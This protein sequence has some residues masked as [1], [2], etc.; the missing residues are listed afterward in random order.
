MPRIQSLLLT[1]TFGVALAVWLNTVP[2]R[3]GLALDD[4]PRPTPTQD[5]ITEPTPRPAFMPIAMRRWDPR[6]P[7]PLIPV[8]QGYVDRMTRAERAACAPATHVMLDGRPGAPESRPVGLLYADRGDLELDFYI[9][10]ALEVSGLVDVA[11]ATCEIGPRL[12]MGVK[13]FK[14]LQLPP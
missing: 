13:T 6:V 11:P 3:V 14:V 2:V 5:I 1:A 9:E 7:P 10:Y 12:I 8:W 4:Q